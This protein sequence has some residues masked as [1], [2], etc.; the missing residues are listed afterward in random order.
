MEKQALGRLPILLLF[1]AAVLA[2]SCAGIVPFDEAYRSNQF[3]FTARV[4]GRIEPPPQF[5]TYTGQR[6]QPIAGGDMIGWV[7]VPILSWKGRL[8]ATLLVYSTRDSAAC[9]YE[10]Q[11]GRDYIIFANPE[12]RGSWNYNNAWPK[13]TVFPVPATYQCGATTPIPDV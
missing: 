5:S 2:C 8:P 13:G 10:F 12:G 9:G 4:V 7:T 11:I 6:V 1:P 3:V